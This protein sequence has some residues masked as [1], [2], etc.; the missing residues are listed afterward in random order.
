MNKTMTIRLND[1]LRRDLEEI[2]KAEDKSIS[3]LVRESLK[4]YVAIH[5]FRKLRRRTLP[6]AEAQGLVTDEDIFNSIS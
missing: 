6:L 3:E 5:Q 1:D 4:N 2:S